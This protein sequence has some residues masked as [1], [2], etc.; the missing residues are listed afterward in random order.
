M[1][2]Q[3]GMSRRG[4]GGGGGGGNPTAEVQALLAGTPGFAIDWSDTAVLWQDNTKLTPVTAAGQTIG[5]VDTKFGT[6]VYTLSEAGAALGVWQGTYWQGDGVDDRFIT[7]VATPILNNVPAVTAF[8]RVRLDTLT[9]SPCLIA[10]STATGT[11]PRFV[12]DILPTGEVRARVRR[13]DADAE[14]TFPSAAGVIVAGTA[15]T[16]RAEVDYAGTGACRVWVNGTLVIN[17]TLANAVGNTSATNSVRH[18]HSLGLSNTLSQF[19]DGNFGRVVVAPKLL[20]GAETT[21]C[22]NWVEAAAV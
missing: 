20:T 10:F 11:A 17:Q 12:I 21:S 3:M 8:A 7:G 22:I 9:T 6:T 4:G 1:R 2:I 16:I 18:R 15:Y 13:L 14:N 5:A 19:V